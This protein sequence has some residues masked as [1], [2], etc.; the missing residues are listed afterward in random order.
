MAKKKLMFK[1]VD[2]VKKGITN[3]LINTGIGA[4]CSIG[5]AYGI[6]KIKP[7]IKNPKILKV[8]GGIVS[9]S[10]YALAAFA[11]DEKMQIAGYSIG[12][13]G[14]Y[15][16][17]LDMSPNT[18]KQQL[19]M[20]ASL[21][22]IDTDEDFVGE[23]AKL[24]KDESEDE[25]INEN[26]EGNSDDNEDSEGINDDEFDGIDDDDF[27]GIDDMDDESELSDNIFDYV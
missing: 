4:S 12:A 23:L 3:T 26:I 6:N 7:K 14:A 5:T 8:F 15:Q 20:T 27:E 21:S 25:S 24:Y 9:L 18:V 11:E 10:G 16:A 2:S 1:S 17:S 22:G 19:T 13:V